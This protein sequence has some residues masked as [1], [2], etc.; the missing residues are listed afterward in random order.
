MFSG[1]T[2]KDGLDVDRA[3]QQPAGLEA[4]DRHRADQG[5]AQHVA[6][7]HS[8]RTQS[9]CSRRAH[10]QLVENFKHVC[11]RESRNDRQWHDRQV[12]LRRG[13]GE[14][15]RLVEVPAT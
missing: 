11:A 13:Q 5:V 7:D 12:E 2:G 6:H 10:V 9:L 15:G 14:V 4:E 3:G 1:L 8:A